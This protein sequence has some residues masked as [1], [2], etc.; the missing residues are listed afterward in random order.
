M[1]RVPER[2]WGWSRRCWGLNE[3]QAESLCPLHDRQMRAGEPLC[4]LAATWPHPLPAASTFP[5]RSGGDLHLSVLSPSTFSAGWGVPALC[6]PELEA[7]DGGLRPELWGEEPGRK[8][9]PHSGTSLALQQH[10]PCCCSASCLCF[11]HLFFFF[12]PFFNAFHCDAWVGK[13]SQG[14]TFLWLKWDICPKWD[15]F[16]KILIKKRNQTHV[17]FLILSITSS[18][19]FVFLVSRGCTGIDIVGQKLLILPLC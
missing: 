10:H 1:E 4:P 14:P 15:G 16:Q 11:C 12:S 18:A 7:A 6:Q 2:P 17:M 3:V 5:L 8:A 9:A 19:P 13:A